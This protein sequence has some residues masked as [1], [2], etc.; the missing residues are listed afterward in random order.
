MSKKSMNGT[1][2]RKISDYFVMK[3]HQKKLMVKL[4]KQPVKTVGETK[5]TVTTADN[6]QL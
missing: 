3:G 2:S 1:V 4:E 5:R 6:R